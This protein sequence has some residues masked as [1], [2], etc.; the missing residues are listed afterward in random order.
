MKGRGRGDS[1]QHA[2]AIARI[3]EVS[4][5]WQERSTAEQRD[6]FN[7]LLA[8]ALCEARRYSDAI[9]YYDMVIES[10]K[11]VTRVATS[12]HYLRLC[13]ERSGQEIPANVLVPSH[14]NS[15]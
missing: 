12:R 14:R 15:R 11:N 13:R 8:H 9:P 5:A 2:R 10:S 1:A 4:H 7:Y 6:D 3:E